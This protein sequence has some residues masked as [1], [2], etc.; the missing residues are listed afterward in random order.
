MGSDTIVV[1]VL[2][3]IFALAIALSWNSKRK[4]QDND[5]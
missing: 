5:E 3:A 1:I 2:F 4:K